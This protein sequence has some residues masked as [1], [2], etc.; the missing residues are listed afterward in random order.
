MSLTYKGI[1]IMVIVAFV[2]WSGVETVPEHEAVGT[3]LDVLL[4]I[5]GAGVAVY[6][7]FRAGGLTWFGKRK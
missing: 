6:G 1:A 7:R 4:T 2:R 5:I 3:F